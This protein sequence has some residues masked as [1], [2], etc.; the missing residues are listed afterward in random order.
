MNRDK[1][2]TA[3]RIA[4]LLKLPATAIVKGADPNAAQDIVVIL[5]NDYAGP[6]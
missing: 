1:P 3:A 6:P 4:N 2:M 5:G